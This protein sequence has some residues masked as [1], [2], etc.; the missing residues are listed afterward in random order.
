MSPDQVVAGIEELEQ[1]ITELRK[2]EAAHQGGQPEE[3]AAEVARLQ[4]DLDGLW[5]LRR[6][7]DAASRAGSDVPTEVRSTGTVG[8]Y[9]Q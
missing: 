8:G 6:R 9:E 5:D 1:R 7:Q 3:A 2:Q 4:T